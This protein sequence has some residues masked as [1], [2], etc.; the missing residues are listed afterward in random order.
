MCDDDLYR[1]GLPDLLEHIR[2]GDDDAQINVHRRDE[3]ALELE[4]S[5]LDRLR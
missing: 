1:H 2:I 3:A 4:L 5:K